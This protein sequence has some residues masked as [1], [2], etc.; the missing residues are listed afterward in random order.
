MSP[1]VIR[2]PG[3]KIAEPV[4]KTTELIETLI[5]S[6]ESV[7]VKKL[8]N[9]DRNWA[10]WD[11][12]KKDFKSHQA[13]VLLP[14]HVR[15]SRFFPPLI[16]DIGKP[17]NRSVSIN[18]KWPAVGVICN[19]R[20]IWYSAKGKS[21]N[22]WTTSPKSEFSTLAPASFV[23]LFKP[24][25]ST[26][27]YQALTINSEDEI[28]YDYIDEVF[29]TSRLN[30]SCQ[31]FKADGLDLS[32]TLTV[33]QKLVERLMHELSNG[34]AAL[35]YFVNSLTK[36]A[37]KEIAAEAYSGWQRDNGYKNLNPYSLV[38]P[39]NVLYELTKQ[40][41]FAI[42]KETEACYYGSRLVQAIFGDNRGRSVYEVVSSLVDNF[43][44]IY[45]ILLGA[46]QTRKTRAGGSFETHVEKMLLHGNIPHFPQ[47]I[48]DGRKPDFILP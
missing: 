32:P 10:V 38:M 14:A 27:D 7:L 17:H 47:P 12:E 28:L 1:Y 20:F 23:L 16:P 25:D 22:H 36:R 9:N 3:R 39:G 29:G 34:P 13:G 8:A 41:E 40:R 19:S 15:E 37:P 35:N 33:L 45:R 6:S 44:V 11:V 24:K 46:V 5:R 31:I 30:F 48:F 42:Y 2:D 18:V 43:D 21:E 4:E 26:F